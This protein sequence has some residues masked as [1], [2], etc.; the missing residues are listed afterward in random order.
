MHKLQATKLS[1]KKATTIDPPPSLPPPKYKKHQTPPPPHN[2]TTHT[3]KTKQQHTK[4]THTH[5]NKQ[6]THTHEK[7]C[8][9]GL[10]PC[11]AIYPLLFASQHRESQSLIMIM[12][13]QPA[14][15]LFIS[16]RQ[17]ISKLSLVCLSATDSTSANSAWLQREEGE[18]TRDW[19]WRHSMKIL[20]RCCDPDLDWTQQ[21]QSFHKTTTVMTSHKTKSGGCK[22]V[23]NPVDMAETDTV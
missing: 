15:G 7:V 12:P 10:S 9:Q 2:K 3:H 14:L 16:N 21:S 11:T 19:H 23:S 17:Y 6:T 20:N 22:W 4:T 13:S 8:S 1:T 18:K 5:T